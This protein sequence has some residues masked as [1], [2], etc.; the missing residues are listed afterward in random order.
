MACEGGLHLRWNRNLQM[1][2]WLVGLLAV[3]TGLAFVWRR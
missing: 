2:P 1:L 3:L